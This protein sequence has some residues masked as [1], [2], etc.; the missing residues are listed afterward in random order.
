M[1][2][3]VPETEASILPRRTNFRFVEG[4]LGVHVGQCGQAV[5]LAVSHELD[6]QAGG[7]QL[8]L[9]RHY[10]PLPTTRGSRGTR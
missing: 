6:Q 5:P 10:I 3:K 9:E 8:G 7:D 4:R 1:L 2:H